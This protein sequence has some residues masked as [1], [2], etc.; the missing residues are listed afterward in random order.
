MFLFKYKY[1]FIYNFNDL[2]IIQ[3]VTT[4]TT[5]VVPKK[6]CQ[7]NAAAYAT[8]SAMQQKVTYPIQSTA[9]TPN[10]ANNKGIIFLFAQECLYQ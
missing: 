5:G 6:Q 3:A 9:V 4:Y 10:Q 7:A 2:T 8:S 1:S